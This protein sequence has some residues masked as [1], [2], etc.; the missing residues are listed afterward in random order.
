[1]MYLGWIVERGPADDV[2]EDPLHPYT[3]A[4]LSA[5]PVA[6]PHVKRARIRLEG[7]VPTPVD[8]PPG[9]RFCPRCFMSDNSICPV[10]VPPMREVR[11]GRFVRCHLVK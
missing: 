3:K 10:E 4:L 1:V 11:P 6:D 5:V 2:C 9:C 7:D 8:P